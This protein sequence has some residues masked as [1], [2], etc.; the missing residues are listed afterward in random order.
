[1]SLRVFVI[2]MVNAIAFH[3]FVGAATELDTT[4][5]M[6]TG[7]HMISPIAGARRTVER[8]MLDIDGRSPERTK[9]RLPPSA[10]AEP[11]ARKT[12]GKDQEENKC[13]WTRIY[14]LDKA[15]EDAKK[16]TEKAARSLEIF[17]NAG[18]FLKLLAQRALVR[19][20]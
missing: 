2:D 1:M 4:P 17:Q 18:N 7:C 3:Q 13:T 10:R 5:F 6:M 8:T 19:V 14:G 11:H 20:Q 16:Y 12:V 9:I 15:R